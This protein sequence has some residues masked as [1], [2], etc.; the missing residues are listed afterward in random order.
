MVMWPGDCKAK[1]EAKTF[2]CHGVTNRCMHMKRGVTVALFTH[3]IERIV[4]LLNTR[5]NIL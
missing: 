4:P 5:I 2:S 3:D 1:M